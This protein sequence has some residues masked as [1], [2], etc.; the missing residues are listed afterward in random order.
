MTL[1]KDFDIELI[2]QFYATVHF[3]QDEACTFR[4]MT[5]G[6]NLESNLVGFGEALGYPR[7]PSANSKGW[8]SHDN[9]FGMT[10][11]VLSPLYI[12]G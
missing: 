8:R 7:S 5:N 11:G 1:N 9:S 6:V 10:K 2:M 3:Q 4:W 12:K